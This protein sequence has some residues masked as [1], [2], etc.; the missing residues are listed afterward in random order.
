MVEFAMVGPVLSLLSLVI[1][2]YALMFNAKNMINHA[3]FM[4]ARAGSTGNAQLSTVE[5]AYTRALIPLYGGGRNTVELATAYA[6]ARA[7][8]LGNARIELLNPTKES[9][10]DWADNALQARYGARA[11]PN[12]GLPFRNATEIKSNS[13]QSIHDANLIKLK[14]VHGYE[15]KVPL[16]GP[17]IH[18]MMKWMDSGRDSFAS[19]MYEQN[20]LPLV[21]HVTM[22]MQS[23]PVEP[24]NPISVAG[25][26]NNG[27]PTDPGFTE[28]FLVPP[29]MCLTIGCTVISTPIGG[30][31]GG[32]GDDGGGDGTGGGTCTAVN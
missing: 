8:L 25:L 23:D 29:P 19:A 15:L 31:D 3:A 18:F 10:D 28:D 26:G 4:A 17:M 27:Q 30:G 6:K 12:S 21:T 32:G 7:D 5:A 20:R 9:F 1:L 13:G 24:G 16:A 22:Q 2:Q 11:I 14:I